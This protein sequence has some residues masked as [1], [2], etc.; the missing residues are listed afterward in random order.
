M[1]LGG[2][3]SLIFF[4]GGC[5][6]AKTTPNRFVVEKR[7]ARYTVAV[8]YMKARRIHRFTPIL[9]K[10]LVIVGNS[11]DGVVA[12][13]RSNAQE[14]WRM[15]LQDGVEGGAV[16]ENGIM[17]F[18]SSDG[19]LYAVKAISGDR[20]WSYPLGAEGLAP[21]LLVGDKLFVLGGNSVAHCLNA[22]S[23]KLLWTYNRREAANISVRG[24][25]QPA[26]AGSSIVFGFSDGSVVGLN[27][28]SGAI[29]WET[30][31]NRNKRFRDVDATPVVDGDR[32]F[33]SSYDGG[34]YALS[35]KDGTTLWII[36]EGGYD[37]VAIRKNILFFS[38]SEGE[39]LAADKA[40][41][42]IH[43]RVKNPKG[44]STGPIYY[45]GTV[46]VGEM[47][48]ALRFLDAKNGDL[49]GIFEPG[50]GVTSRVEIDPESSE[51]YFIS[52]DA[53]LYALRAGWKRYAREWMWE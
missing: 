48:G 50:R 14:L 42:K 27:P 17:Y 13:K 43:W 36:E 1:K 47:A 44:I 41:G 6:I 3:I 34:L 5:T 12:Y 21:P 20:I 26:L 31:I 16:L 52:I 8:D 30:N 9:D 40:S 23:G 32:I 46:V 37:Q 51:L 28:S 53:N 39:V 19:Q 2:F 25:A 33:I 49:L 10:D 24:G 38:T 45:K 18:G 35:V 11:I 4:F 15:N 22:K 29:N 7:W